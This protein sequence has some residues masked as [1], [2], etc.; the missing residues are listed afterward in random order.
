[1]EIRENSIVQY[2]CKDRDFPQSSHELNGE[3]P[4]ELSSACRSHPKE[5]LRFFDFFKIYFSLCL[6]VRSSEV[7]D[8]GAVGGGGGGGG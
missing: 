1:M 3:T 4:V 6:S 5:I 2:T 8:E 7:D